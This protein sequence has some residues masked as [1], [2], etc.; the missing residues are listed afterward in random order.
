M[1]AAPV[2]DMNLAASL[3]SCRIHDWWRRRW[4]ES[5]RMELI[6]YPN[7]LIKQVT[8]Q[9]PCPLRMPPTN[10]NEIRVVI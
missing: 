1:L 7:E 8:S 2:C 9:Y 5:S 6:D 3:S 10:S 4:V